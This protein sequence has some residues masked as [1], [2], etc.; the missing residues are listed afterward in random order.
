MGCRKRKPASKNEGNRNSW[1]RKWG[2]GQEEEKEKEEERKKVAPQ[3]EHQEE[4]VSSWEYPRRGEEYIP[5]ERQQTEYKGYENP[6]KEEW[7]NWWES[8]DKEAKQPPQQHTAWMSSMEGRG[9]C[10]ENKSTH[11]LPASHIDV[12]QLTRVMEHTITNQMKLMHMKERNTQSRDANQG[13]KTAW[14]ER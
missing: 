1:N 14:A 5:W 9:P 6:E 10:F 3:A 12:Q 4:G 13:D 8:K 2:K 11:Q 7:G